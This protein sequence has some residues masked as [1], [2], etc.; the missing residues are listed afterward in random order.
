MLQDHRQA[1][2]IVLD[3]EFTLIDP[4]HTEDPGLI[5]RTSSNVTVTDNRFK[6]NGY[7]PDTEN[8]FIA[9]LAGDIVYMVAGQQ[10]NCFAGNKYKSAALLTLGAGSMPE[11]QRLKP[12]QFDALFP[13]A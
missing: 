7:A 3:H 4:E 13:C 1:G 6:K 10:D 5:D 12:A 11:V 8:P 2:F 9:Q